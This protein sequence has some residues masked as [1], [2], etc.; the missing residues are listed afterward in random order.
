MDAASLPRG[1]ACIVSWKRTLLILA[2]VVL[3]GITRCIVVALYNL[4]WHPL[5]H[6]P[7]P[8]L[9]I[10]FPALKKFQCR[11]GMLDWEIRNLHVGNVMRTGPNELS[12]IDPRAWRDI[13][14]RTSREY[15][16]HYPTNIGLS[17]KKITLAGEKDHARYRRAL[18]PAFS[19]NALLEQERLIRVYADLL[20][21]KLRMVADGSQPT[22]M[23]CWFGRATFD[24]IGDL[25][26]GKAL[27]GLAEGRSNA[28]LDNIA[29]MIRSMP[30]LATISSLP[31]IGG[32]LIHLLG[33]MIQQSKRRH[34]EHVAELADDRIYGGEKPPSHR[35]DLMDHLLQSRG[36]P[37]E[38][39]NEEIVVNADL[40]MVAGSETTASLLS[41]L[42]FW[43]LKTPRSYWLLTDE[44]RRAFSDD[45]EITLAAMRTRLPYL[46]AC[47]KEALRLFPPVPIS[48][49]R[50]I[51]DG[52]PV[53][54][55]GV[56]VP[57]QVCCVL[58]ITE[59]MLTARMQTCVG[60]HSL[61]ASHSEQN[62]YRAHEFHPE[63][64]LP[65]SAASPSPFHHDRRDASQPFGYGPRGCM[66][67]NLA[68]YEAR[69]IMT[70]ILWNFDLA[71]NSQSTGWNSQ[72]IFALWEKPPL[73]I[74]VEPRFR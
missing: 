47:I 2:L 24:I 61:A 71:L 8:R 6:V 15:P 19:N 49:M 43:L 7:G 74:D 14:G 63:R 12:F 28:W 46:D 66:G 34:L 67:Q 60:V 27:N 18:L 30:K 59:M 1:Q 41:G 13:Y 58:I 32:L 56:S 16:K 21:D 52:P 3:F 29:S 33:P 72:R 39:T 53:E 44:V 5:S 51:P 65:D 35:G 48:L 20:V 37:Y 68:Q 10:A 40:L 69:L 31:L 62:F 22:D 9:W 26:F 38:M 42:T 4:Y 70:K 17:T 64:W 55:A 50:R 11:A 25:T 57:P 23:N 73:L 54:I 45:E 36:T